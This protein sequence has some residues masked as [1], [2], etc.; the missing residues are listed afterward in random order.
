MIGSLLLTS[1]FGLAQGETNSGKNE[2]YYNEQIDKFAIGL[3]ETMHKKAHLTKRGQFLSTYIGDLEEKEDLTAKDIENV[4]K[5]I[6]EVRKGY[7]LL[8]SKIEEHEV[9]AESV[10]EKAAVPA[11]EIEQANNQHQASLDK[12]VAFKSTIAEELAVIDAVEERVNGLRPK[13]STPAG[14]TAKPADN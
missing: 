5:L 9:E 11:D 12:I 4:G 3:E 13:I 14:K 1:L 10:V 8:S 2:K 7:A 6:T